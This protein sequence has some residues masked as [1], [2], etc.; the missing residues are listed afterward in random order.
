MIEGDSA[1]CAEVYAI[2]SSISG[3]PIKQSFAITG[4]MNQHGEVQPIG[5]VNEKIEGFYSLCKQDG[6]NGDHGVIIPERNLI[7][8]MLNSEVIEAVAAGKFRIYA[9]DNIED[10]IKILTGMSPGELQADGAYPEGTFNFAVAKALKELSEA[11]GSE[12]NN[13]DNG[14]GKKKDDDDAP[15]CDTCGDK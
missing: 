13:D 12:K 4:S 1:T 3:I 8:L 11:L 9:I 14:N 7:N 2:L 15:A 10:G 6:L 5:G